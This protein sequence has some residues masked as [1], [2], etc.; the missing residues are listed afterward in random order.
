MIDKTFLGPKYRKRTTNTCFNCRK[1]IIHISKIHI[2]GPK[3]LYHCEAC[4]GAAEEEAKEL[5]KYYGV[6]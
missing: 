3:F 2:K 1:E 5:K 6:I 4:K